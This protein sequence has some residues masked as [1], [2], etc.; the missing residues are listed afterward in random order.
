MLVL[1]I[2]TSGILCSVGWVRDDKILLEYNIE[3]PNIHATLLADL[4]LEGSKKLQI[5]CRDIN[6]VA[7]ALGPGS[8]TGLRIGMSYAKGLCYGLK[9]PIIGVT[10]FEVLAEQAPINTVPVYT[11]I[12]GGHGKYYLGVFKDGI[13]INKS[14]VITINQIQKKINKNSVIMVNGS[15]KGDFTELDKFAALIMET[16]YSAGLLCKIALKKYKIN[17]KIDLEL[18]EPLYLQSF[19]GVK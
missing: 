12:N 13:T 4:V 11:L 18:L 7:V 17:N 2:E 8:F 15:G 1:G 16:K 5:E 19:A 9:I 10:N 14:E 3:M 6:L